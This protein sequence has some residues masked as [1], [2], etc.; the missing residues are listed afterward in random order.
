[1]PASP[2]LA[3]SCW[4]LPAALAGVLL[5]LLLAVE[6]TQGQRV[7]W[8][9]PPGV[10]ALALENDA[11]LKAL[12]AIQ[13]EGEVPARRGLALALPTSNDALLRGDEA[14]FYSPLDATVPGLRQFGWEGGRYGFVRNAARTPAGMTFTRLHQGIDIRPVYRDR[15]GEPLDTVRAIAPGLVVYANRAPDRSNYG[16]YVVVRHVWDGSPVYSLYA[17]LNAVWVREGTPVEAGSPLGRLGYTGTGINRARAHLHLEV[18]LL[19]N[20]EFPRWH[21]ATTRTPNHHGVYNGRNLRGVD[22]AGLFLQLEREPGLTF[23]EFVLRQPVAYRVAV[24][25]ELRIDLLERYPWLATDGDLRPDAQRAWIVG[26]TR[27]GVP[28]EVT[29]ERRRVARPEVVYVAP[30]IVRLHLS[31]GGMLGRQGSTYR[32][33]PQGLNYIA[34]LT[35]TRQGV[36]RWL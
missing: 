22:V 18:A 25:G 24:P 20:T 5:G 2:N 34:L 28:V 17:H 29:R 31:T 36:P 35:T 11:F 7:G 21:D 8:D 1:M 27:E 23:R 6:P 19:L 4:R 32:L 14:A 10:D 12:A 16:K 3:R 9:P 15:H 33:T 26:F 13:D 30:D